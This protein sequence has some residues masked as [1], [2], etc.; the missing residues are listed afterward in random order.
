MNLN[1]FFIFILFLLISSKSNAFDVRDV[2]NAKVM[3]KASY[4]LNDTNLI[5]VESAEILLENISKLNEALKIKEKE[6]IKNNKKV[7]EKIKESKVLDL[8]L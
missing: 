2:K 6:V 5:D 4:T 3:S 8:D 7:I 1:L